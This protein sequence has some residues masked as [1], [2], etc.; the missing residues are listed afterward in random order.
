VTQDEPLYLPRY[1]ERILERRGDARIDCVY[2]LPLSLP[3]MGSVRT[4]LYFAVNYYGPILSAYLAGLRAYHLV[5]DL[6][7]RML[8][9][10]GTF[11]SISGVCAKYGIPCKAIPNIN[12]SEIVAAIA[13]ARP[14]VV[15]S[16]ASSQ[17][18]KP[19]LLAVPS[20]A[21][22]NI[23]SS[24]LPRFRGFNANFWVLAKGESVT[25]VTIHRMTPQIDGGAILMQRTIPIQPQWSL[26][27]LYL[28]VI[29][30][31]SAMVGECLARLSE[32][33]AQAAEPDLALG[34][35]FSLPTA[36]DV[37]EFRA[38]GRRFFRYH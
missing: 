33:N 15:F 6:V 17:I 27:D 23:H 25:G 18:F 28:E 1:L 31:G 34:S 37:R 9:R 32:L 35:Y 3:R 4:R 20:Q 21:C 10:V 29:D 19:P 7:A 26:H 38:R 2:V 36:A 8:N 14:D 24:L 11:H 13:D 30:V 22:L 16:L 12:A 5:G